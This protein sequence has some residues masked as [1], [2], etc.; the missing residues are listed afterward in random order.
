MGQ[1]HTGA[2]QLLASLIDYSLCLS[3]NLLKVQ[4]PKHVLLFKGSSQTPLMLIRSGWLVLNP[5]P[6]A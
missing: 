5:L 2:K 3:P 1:I 6:Q 4:N